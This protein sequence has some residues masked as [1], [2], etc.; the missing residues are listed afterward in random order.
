M[1]EPIQNRTRNRFQNQSGIRSGT[2]D[3]NQNQI[4]TVVKAVCGVS[5]STCI[6]SNGDLPATT[7][8]RGRL[9]PG[10]ACTEISGGRR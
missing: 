6:A 5:G 9:V 4:Q 8:P 3:Q 10:D 7:T 1:K 2:T